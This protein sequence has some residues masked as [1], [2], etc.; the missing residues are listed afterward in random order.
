MHIYNLTINTFQRRYA[1]F[2][3]VILL[4]NLEKKGNQGEI[5]KVR[6]GYA[7]NILIPRKIAGINNQFLVAFNLLSICMY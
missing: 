2:T 6:G 3:S 5:V 7:R 4:Q 1:S